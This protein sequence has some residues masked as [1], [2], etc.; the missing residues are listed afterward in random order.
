MDLEVIVDKDN[1][2]MILYIICVV[3]NIPS[4][5]N[6]YTHSIDTIEYTQNIQVQMILCALFTHCLYHILFDS[7]TFTY[8][9]AR[10]YTSINTNSLHLHIWISAYNAFPLKKILQ[11]STISVFHPYCV[12]SFHQFSDTPSI[13]LSCNFQQI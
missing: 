10:F 12:D 11:N 7:D 4:A 6:S 1:E 8:A 2:P 5:C 13:F 3:C 9:I